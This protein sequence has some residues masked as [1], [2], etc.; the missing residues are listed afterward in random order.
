MSAL[1]IFDRVPVGS[2]ICWTDGKPRPPENH[3]RALAGWKRDNAEG[4]LVRKRS[5]SVMG[6]SL[7]PASFKVAT[8]GIDDLG[9]VIGPDFRTFPVDSTFHFM[10]VDRPAVGSFRIFD[11]A[12]AD[13]ELLHLASSREHADV[14][15]KN[16][17]FAVT[18]IVEVTADEI[19]ADRIE[20]RAA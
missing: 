1:M 6:Q 5:H 10:I 2:T 3:I 17:G 20:G 13:A 4:R 15:V 16:C 18:T 9:A 12:G 19:A 7:V 14:W 11:G 8:D